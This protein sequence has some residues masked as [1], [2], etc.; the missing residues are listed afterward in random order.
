MEQQLN[1]IIII[2]YA[3]I[4]QIKFGMRPGYSMLPITIPSQNRVSHIF[5]ISY[6]LF[7]Q[8]S[9]RLRAI[10][11]MFVVKMFGLFVDVILEVFL[12]SCMI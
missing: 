12:T 7:F 11:E 9:R 2:F 6:L 4:P 10:F 5:C 8:M 3:L 1:K